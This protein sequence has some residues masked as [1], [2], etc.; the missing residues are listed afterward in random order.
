MPDFSVF[1]VYVLKEYLVIEKTIVCF[2]Y[3]YYVACVFL[4]FWRE[5]NA[6][7]IRK[8]E[9]VAYIFLYVV[10]SNANCI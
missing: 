7:S 6:E 10:V 4:F 9:N 8:V 3:K 1:S 5:K 2:I